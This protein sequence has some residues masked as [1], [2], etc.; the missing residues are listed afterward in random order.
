MGNIACAG[1]R[2]MR[3]LYGVTP[4]APA[5]AGTCRR[6]PAI[7]GVQQAYGAFSN[8]LHSQSF[9]ARGCARALATRTESECM[10]TLRVKM[11]DIPG[12]SVDAMT[13]ELLSLGALS[14]RSATCLWITRSLN[15][16]I[17]GS[18]DLWI[19][20]SNMDCEHYF[21]CRASSNECT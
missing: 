20:Q 8:R 16:P 9:D 21:S 15:H 6:L 10:H 14:A 13:D 18:P 11:E 17:F 2:G 19:T 4:G 3:L 5:S 12:P 1:P 7:H